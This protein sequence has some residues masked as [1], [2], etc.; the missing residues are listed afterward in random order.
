LIFLSEHLACKIRHGSSC[1]L[2]LDYDG[3]L[4]DFTPTP[5]EIN[6]D[7][8]LVDLIARLA[9]YPEQLRLVILSGRSLDQIV[10]LV[11]VSGVLLAGTYG[12]EYQT[13][14]GEKVQLIDFQ[15]DQPI[16]DQ[17]KKAW[18]K[19][20]AGKRGYFIEEKR[21]A[22]ALHARWA[23][24]AESLDCV[25]QARAAAEEIT[26]GKK[27]AILTGD[28][29]LEVAPLSANK[30]EAVRRLTARFPCKNCLII[31]IGDDDKDEQAFQVVNQLGGETIVVAAQSR[32]TLAKYRLD[33]PQQVR[34]WLSELAE[35]L[36]TGSA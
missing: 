9:R 8:Q 7:P 6:Q 36:G 28:R 22:L 29:F 20:V 5:Q 19:I 14:P 24:P 27:V 11:P 15:A 31:Y 33:N 13:W 26:N 32:G 4:A 25:A 21:V 35:L 2:F 12:V 10:Q 18:E 17:V 3:T 30:G 23:D 16:L 1:W 34:A